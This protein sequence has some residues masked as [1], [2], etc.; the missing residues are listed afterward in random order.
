MKFLVVIGGP[1]AAGKTAMAIQVAQAFGAEIISADSRQFYR[2]MNIGTAKPSAEEL[3]S[4]KHHFIG[5]IGI[6]DA[7]SAGQYETDALAFLENY[8][9]HHDIAVMVGG[10]GLFINAVCAGLDYFPA[11]APEV[12]DRVRLL[13]EQQGLEGLQKEVEALDPDYYQQVDRQNPA[14]LRRALEVCYAAGAPYSSFRKQNTASRPFSILKIALSVPTD[15][16]YDR[17]NRRVDA[18]MRA[19]LL[20]EA[21]GLY[22]QR[23]LYAL[24]TVGYQEFSDYFENKCSLEEAVSKVKQN[25]RNYAKRQMTWFRRDPDTHWLNADDTAGAVRLVQETLISISH[26]VNDL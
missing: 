5:H 6:N 19:G 2:E 14:R 10:S 4:V 24:Q 9:N 18:M 16:L 7:Y 13:H 25:T 12:K 20:D 15:A 23:H 11:I 26:T 1:T 3:A 22:P 21:R 17:I 8:F